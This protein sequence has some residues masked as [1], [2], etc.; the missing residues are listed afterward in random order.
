MPVATFAAQPSSVSL[1]WLIKEAAWKALDLGIA[2]PFTA[3]QISFDPESEALKGVRLDNTWVTARSDV[4][5]FFYP[6]PSLA[7]ALETQDAGAI[8]GRKQEL[9]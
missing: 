1:S 5:R 6:R 3:L 8:N 9:S 7:T 2:V 4:V